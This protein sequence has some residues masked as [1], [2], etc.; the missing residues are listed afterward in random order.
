[1]FSVLRI[2]RRVT[3]SNLELALGLSGRAAVQLGSRGYAHLCTGA[4]E[5]LRL[6]QLTPE[7]ASEVVGSAAMAELQ[8]LRASGRGLLVL[9]A[10]LGNWDLLACAAG[11]AGLPVNVVTRQIKAAS[12]NRYWMRQRE[13]CGVRLLPARRSAAAVLAALRRN[14]IVA[15]VLDQHEPGGLEVPYFG[16]NAATADSLARLARATRAPVVPAFLLRQ[17]REYVLQLMKPVSVQATADRR[18]DILEATALFTMIIEQQVVLHP[19]Q[20]L[21]LHRRWKVGLPVRRTERRKTH[22]SFL[23]G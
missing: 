21:W 16:R 14:E 9:S 18:R 23:F 15:M 22:H 2:R 4:L 10:H 3:L 20:W 5:F 8:R 7:R 12:I 17:G 19:E 13:S 11:R 1:V 6:R